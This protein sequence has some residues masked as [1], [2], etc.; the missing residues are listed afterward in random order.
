MAPHWPGI[1]ILTF[2]IVLRFN[3]CREIFCDRK[4]NERYLL[5]KT[6]ILAFTRPPI[7]PYLSAPDSNDR[8][9]I[10][11]S[12]SLESGVLEGKHLEFA[13]HGRL[14]DHD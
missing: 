8:L 12:R 11:V 2:V 1:L 4:L 10:I 14:E 5:R 6:S 7:F 13:G 3:V 9:V